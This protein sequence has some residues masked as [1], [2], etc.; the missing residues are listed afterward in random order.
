V[1]AKS[2]ILSSQNLELSYKVDGKNLL[3]RII[4]ALED[5]TNPL[6][7]D[8]VFILGELMDD[9]SLP[10][11][12]QALSQTDPEIVANAAYV[13]G[14]FQDKKAVPYLINVCKNYDL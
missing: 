2:N 8:S 7:S 3:S 6:H 12:R 11:L 13:L 1:I 5:N 9:S 4:N 14:L 10:A